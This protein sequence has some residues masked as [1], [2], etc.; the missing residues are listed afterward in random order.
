MKNCWQNVSGLPIPNPH[1]KQGR[2]NVIVR[3]LS[4]RTLQAI[5]ANARAHDSSLYPVMFS[6]MVLGTIHVNPPSN[7]E[8]LVVP[9][10]FTPVNLRYKNLI[11]PDEHILSSLGMNVLLASD[12]GRFSRKRSKEDIWTLAREIRKQMDEQQEQLLRIGIWAQPLITELINLMVKKAES[13][14]GG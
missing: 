2:L 10:T 5:I 14:D 8:N 9:L 13:N 12:L 7:T 4:G 6:A 11:G 3:T 1:A